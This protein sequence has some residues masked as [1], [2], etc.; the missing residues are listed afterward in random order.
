VTSW[1]KWMAGELDG[2]RDAGRW[3]SLR[4]F[5]SRGPAGELDGTSIVS[6]AS[7][8]YLGLSSH[9][10]VINA[11]C[12][13]ARRWGTSATASRLV[14]G[15]RP[16]H[17]DLELDLADW[18]HTDRALVFATGYAANVSVPTV[19]GGPDV[20]VFSDELNHASIIDG[21]RLSRSRL[22]V[23]PHLDLDWLADQLHHTSGRSIV[24]TDAVFSMDG[25]LADTVALAALCATHGALLVLDEAHSVVGPDEQLDPA[26]VIVRVGT[27]S[28]TLGSL[29]GFVAA[30]TDVIDLLIN[31]ARP[32]IFSTGL[33]P[34]DAAAAQAALSILRS[35][36]G[37]DL[38]ARL[39]HV[40]D[41]VKPGHPSPIIPIVIGDERAALHAS[42]ALAERGILIP[43]IRPPTV[44]PGT[45]RL[46]L[47]LS[48]AHTDQMIDNLIDA[49]VELVPSAFTNAS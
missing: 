41:R 22:V 34:P 27:L 3:R 31:R 43:A 46:R 37:R 24:V 4:T 16:A 19:F 35:D 38:I 21:C 18:K 33:T 28:K 9:P 39:E 17:T 49:L 13:A 7:N 47:A 25:D 10:D 45:S 14:V 1:Q 40:T 2:V 6:Y 11:A 5:D 29:G 32:F 23:Y 30:G 15:N 36:A 48:A 12:E 8:D 42:Q 44:P 26:A 20:T